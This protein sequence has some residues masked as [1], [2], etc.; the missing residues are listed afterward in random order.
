MYHYLKFKSSDR[1][2][3][4][5]KIKE[6]IKEKKSAPQNFFPPKV[7]CLLPSRMEK[8]HAKN[9]PSVLVPNGIQLAPKQKENSQHDPIPLS[10]KGNSKPLEAF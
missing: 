1:P 3:H 6:K 10:S 7:S 4:K 8:V 9:L 2:A 5:K